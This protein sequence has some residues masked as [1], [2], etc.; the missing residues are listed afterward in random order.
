MRSV[1]S[2]SGAS[3][4]V[5]RERAQLIGICLV[6]LL[7]RLA[8]VWA[9][10]DAGLFS[11]MQD[12]HDRAMYL[13][14]HGELMPDAF[15]PPAY[16]VFL[17]AVSLVA[18]E[19][20]L[21]AARIVQAFLGA[22]MIA[23]TGLLARRISGPRGGLAAAAIVAVYPAWLIYP[24]YIMAE[25]L[26]AFLTL[27]GL[28]CWSQ[29]SLRMAALAGVALASSVQSRAVG[30]ATVAG[31]GVVTLAGMTM[32]RRSSSDPPGDIEGGT[33]GGELRTQARRAS[34]RRLVVLGAAFLLAMAPWV[35][36]N[37]KLFG[38]FV[39][40]DTASG[41]NF[42]LG[43]NP[44][45]TGRLELDQLPDITQRYWSRATTDV[46]RSRVGLEAG[47]AYIRS[48]PLRASRLAVRKLW[49]LLGLEGREHAWT[50]SY[51]FHGARRP[52]V[53]WA[54]GLAILLSFPLVMSAALAGLFRPGLSH[55]RLG[56]IVA[57]VLIAAAVLHVASFGESRFHVPWVPLLAIAAGRLW[58]PSA[59]SWPRPRRGA[60]IVMLVALGVL[61]LSQAPALIAQL[62]LLAS[63]PTPL[64]LPY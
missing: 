54:W 44:V 29:G 16:P 59:G 19:H 9:C 53:V 39:P 55:T 40:T 26:F 48:E 25:T 43:N 8:V 51:H 41:Y 20:F 61:W 11:D 21:L 46:E 62:G 27:A 36:R 22:G 2:S 24:V 63:S 5:G 56:L 64:G 33:A 50:Y 15:R 60:L 42:L 47:L 3:H 17:A 45:A 57:A 7:L 28:W 58:M 13:R 18:G 10:A 6:G 52:A 12:Y 34:A 14:Q 32:W 30:I 37:Y 38:A 35:V 1:P 31:I 49:Y 4:P 23:L